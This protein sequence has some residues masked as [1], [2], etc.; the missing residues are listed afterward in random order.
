MLEK[1][2]LILPVDIIKKIDANRGDLSQ[3]EFINFLIESQLKEEGGANGIA[4]E[5]L[6]SIKS[7]IKK[8]LLREETEKGKYVTREEVE[9]FQQ[10]VKKALVRAEAAEKKFTTKEEIQALQQDTKKLLKSFLDFFIGYGLELGKQSPSDELAEIT[11]KLQGL[12]EDL[13]SG[14]E[15]REVKIKWK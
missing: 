2:M 4:S 11:S 6:A 13:D 12:E 5:K 14:E 1:G 10:D 8:I 3:A 7:D 9:A 15:G